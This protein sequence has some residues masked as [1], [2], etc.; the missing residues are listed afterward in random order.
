MRNSQLSGMLA[1]TW[2]LWSLAGC[3][4][5]KVPVAEQPQERVVVTMVNGKKITPPS[6]P[7]KGNGIEFEINKTNVV[8]IMQNGQISSA[9]PNAANTNTAAPR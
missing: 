4:E 2:L 5:P 1:G 9:V 3:T 6:A 7:A 8:E